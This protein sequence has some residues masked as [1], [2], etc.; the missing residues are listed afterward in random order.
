VILLLTQLVKFFGRKKIPKEL[1]LQVIQVKN[2]IVNFY[3]LK[4]FWMKLIKEFK[5]IILI[6]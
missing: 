4:E 6:R 5:L 1:K 3:H 2:W